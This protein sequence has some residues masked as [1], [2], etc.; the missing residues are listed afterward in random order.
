MIRVF[1]VTVALLLL[2]GG[3]QAQNRITDFRGIKF[4][5]DFSTMEHM[6]MPDERGGLTFYRKYQDDR[7]FQGVPLIE[8]KYGFFKNKLCL[9]LFSARSLD[10]FHA[11]KAYFDANYGPA[12]QTKDLKQYTYAAGDVNIEF[13]YDDNRK[14]AEVSYIYRPIMRDLMPENK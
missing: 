2:A 8:I 13:G 3:A 7:N 10:S 1:T 6:S 5:A 14:V 9:V 12:K 11:L 4:G